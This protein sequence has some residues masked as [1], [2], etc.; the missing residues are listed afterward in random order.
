MEMTG[1]TVLMGRTRALRGASP[2]M[3]VGM[4]AKIG[5]RPVL[6]IPT[7]MGVVLQVMIVEVEGVM[8][9]GTTNAIGGILS[10]LNPQRHR[11]R[12]E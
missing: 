12:R 11:E 3:G 1:R 10:F 2:P 6:V 8:I 5:D 4:V 7:V 9:T